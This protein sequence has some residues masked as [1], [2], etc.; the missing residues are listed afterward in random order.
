M[1]EIASEVVDDHAKSLTQFIYINLCV[2]IYLG[3]GSRRTGRNEL[4]GGLASAGDDD[5]SAITA[6]WGA[7]TVLRKSNQGATTVTRDLI[8]ALLLPLPDT[9]RLLNCKMGF[10]MRICKQ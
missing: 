8:V 4:T 6:G 1:G 3:R 2:V 7:K 10:P 5:P 9:I